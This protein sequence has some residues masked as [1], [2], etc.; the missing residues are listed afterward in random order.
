MF[1]WV[2]LLT[3]HFDTKASLQM[4]I[5][6][7][8][9]L[10]NTSKFN[11]DSKKTYSFP[12]EF[13]SKRASR[14]T[15]GG[16]KASMTVEA[17]MAFSLFLFFLVGVFSLIFLFIHYGEELQNLQQQGKKLA[18]YAYGTG[19][20]LENND[21][22]IRLR[23][24]ERVESPFSL[25]AMPEGK[26]V[27]QCVIKPWTGYDVTG[28][29]GRKEEEVIVYMTEHGEV[30]HKS[31]NCTHLALSIKAASFSQMKAERNWS[32]G[33]YTACEYCGKQ[34]FATIV[35]LT[36]QGNRYHFSLGC[37]GLKRTVRGV[38][39]SQ[40]PGVPACSKCR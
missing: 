34:G 35:Y 26:M 30:Y 11:P 33:R 3:N 27:V 16:I 37:Q 22:L 40:I 24:E 31:P 9:P 12:K 17:S 2:N 5:M 23:K 6:G 38:Y 1:F 36:E 10:L 32:G 15:P 14:F 13:L 28:G 7:K 21:D 39:L 19:E 29:R 4:S 25:M 20:L 8:I 18:V